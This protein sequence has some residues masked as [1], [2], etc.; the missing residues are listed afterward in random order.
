MNSYCQSCPLQRF[1]DMC[2]GCEYNGVTDYDLFLEGLQRP[3]YKP[4]T[5]HE[6][7]MYDNYPPG[8]IPPRVQEDRV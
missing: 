8:T 4:V 2:D 1:G 5:D 7:F 6:R 3:V